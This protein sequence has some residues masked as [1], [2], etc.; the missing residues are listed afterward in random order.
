[1]LEDEDALVGALT[2]A[3]TVVPELSVDELELEL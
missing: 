3:R 1:V 2:G